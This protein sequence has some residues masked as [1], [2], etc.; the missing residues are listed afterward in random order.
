MTGHELWHHEPD[1]VVAPESLTAFVVMW[2]LVVIPLL[3]GL[4]DG[5]LL[6]IALG[7][8]L[9][10]VALVMSLEALA[11]LDDLVVNPTIVVAPAARGRR[12]RTR[13]ITRPRHGNGTRPGPTR[14][15]A[16]CTRAR[17]NRAPVR[18]VCSAALRRRRDPQH[19]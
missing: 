11:D 16:R 9:S 15:A 19:S 7:G 1:E 12:C 17:P 14:P 8:C 18:P 13:R 3:P 10:I 6:L 4:I 2:L 5:S